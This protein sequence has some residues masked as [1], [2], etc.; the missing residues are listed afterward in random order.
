[1]RTRM[2]FKFFMAGT[3]AQSDKITIES[4]IRNLYSGDCGAKNFHLTIHGSMEYRISMSVGEPF[5]LIAR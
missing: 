4:G 5:R 1:M 3:L 2:M